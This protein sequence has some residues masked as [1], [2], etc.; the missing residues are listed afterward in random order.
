MA[1]HILGL[2]YIYTR[3][4]HPLLLQKVQLGDWCP[5]VIKPCDYIQSVAVHLVVGMCSQPI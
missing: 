4:A 1:S 5:F 3:K 2:I